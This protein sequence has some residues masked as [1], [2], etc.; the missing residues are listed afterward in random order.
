[1]EG[2]RRVALGYLTS[3]WVAGSGGGP[4]EEV[5]QPKLGIDEFLAQLFLV[6]QCAEAADDLAAEALKR[7]RSGILAKGDALFARASEQLEKSSVKKVPNCIS[8]KKRLKDGR[9]RWCWSGPHWTGIACTMWIATPGPRY[10]LGST[11]GQ[12]VEWENPS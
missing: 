6:Q 9:V 4:D 3:C 5:S 7:A 11:N 10:S 8:T 12:R 2:V 1:M